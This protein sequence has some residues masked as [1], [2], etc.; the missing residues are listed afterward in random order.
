MIL[1]NIYIFIDIM[2]DYN[3]IYITIQIFVETTNN[4]ALCDTIRVDLAFRGNTPV[5][6][7]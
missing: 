6:M 7:N 5:G 2:T 3:I 1:Y 4:R